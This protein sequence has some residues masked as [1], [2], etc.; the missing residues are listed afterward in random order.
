MEIY[1]EWAKKFGNPYVLNFPP[2]NVVC[3]SFHSPYL[4][5]FMALLQVLTTEPEHIKVCIQMILLFA[6]IDSDLGDSCNTI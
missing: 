5:F 2:Y 3:I 1:D 4:H 6:G